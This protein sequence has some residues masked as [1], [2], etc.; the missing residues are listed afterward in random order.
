M[1]NVKLP[2]PSVM[3]RALIE[4]DSSFECVFFAAIK[5]TGIF[6]RPTC[7]AKKPKLE[8]VKYFSDT[9]SALAEGYRAC[10]VCFPMQ[11]SGTKPDWLNNL[12]EH[13]S[14]NPDIKIKDADLKKSG[15]D[16][17]KVRRWFNKNHGITF[18]AYMRAMRINRAFGTIKQGAIIDSAYASGFESLS[19]FNDAFKMITGHAPSKAKSNQVITISRI[20]TPLGPMFAGTTT[21]GICLLEFTDR[22]KLEVQIDRLCKLFSAKIVPGEHRFLKLLNEQINDYFD[23]KLTEFTVPL[24]IPGTDFQKRVWQKLIAIPYGETRSYQQQA[25]AINN[26]KAVR[27]VAKTNA[28]NRIAII[29]PCHR[30]IGKNGKL[31]GYAGGLWRKQRLLELEKGVFVLK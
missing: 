23:G 14:S 30:V 9:K 20:L 13:V 28:D 2:K 27:A 31:T 17:A 29:I 6:C 7:T 16:P 19:G 1:N 12:L 21:R 4:R 22:I 10:K 8:N 5:T 25:E 3:Y 26:P 24:D 18:Q 15:I 11:P